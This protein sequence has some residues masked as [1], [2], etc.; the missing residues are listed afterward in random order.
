MLV[1]AATPQHD[2]TRTEAWLPAAARAPGFMKLG[3]RQ[4]PCVSSSSTCAGKCFSVGGTANLKGA[5]THSKCFS[6]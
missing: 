5:A 2:L 1:I 3:L 4:A 6:L